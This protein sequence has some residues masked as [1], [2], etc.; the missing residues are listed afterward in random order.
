M[1][2][3]LEYSERKTNIFSFSQSNGLPSVNIN[4]ALPDEGKK[5]QKNKQNCLHLEPKYMR[6]K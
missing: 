1:I 6:N 5:N 4:K 3:T 2:K